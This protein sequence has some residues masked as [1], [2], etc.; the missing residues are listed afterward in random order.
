M[1]RLD[2][3]PLWLLLFLAIALVQA[4]LWPIRAA[5]AW[6]DILGWALV[7]AGFGLMVAAIREFARHRTTPIP[8]REPSALVK[9]GVFRFS[10]NPIYLGDA[11]VLAGVC[12]IW[13]AWPSL[14]L[15]PLFMVVIQRRF[16]LPEE[17]RLER[18]F[19]PDF[20]AFKAQVRRWL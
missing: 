16:I 3:P 5:G 20:A 13:E 19:G 12:L 18:A 17:R 15:V 8:H 7:A 9:T 2:L 10:R 1:K 4:A 14:V 11:L 6:A